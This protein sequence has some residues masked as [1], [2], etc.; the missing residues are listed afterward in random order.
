MLTLDLPHPEPAIM[1]H[2]VAKQ[3]KRLSKLS[4]ADILSGCN[5]M[6]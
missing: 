4:S 6:R 5:S 1:Q 2:I 3:L